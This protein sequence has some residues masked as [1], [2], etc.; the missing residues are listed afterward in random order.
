MTIC[1]KEDILKNLRSLTF[2]ENNF[3]KNVK[4]RILFKIYKERFERSLH[5]WSKI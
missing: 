1:E 5:L 2:A 4:E 3:E